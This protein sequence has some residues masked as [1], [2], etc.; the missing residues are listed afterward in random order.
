MGQFGLDDWADVAA[1]GDWPV[2]LAGNGA[3]RVVS[4]LFAYPSL[5]AVADLDPDDR[6][7]FEDI[8]TTNFEEVLR[9]LA[10]SVVVCQQ[11]GHDVAELNGRINSVRHALVAT[12]NHH[13]VA[14]DDVQG[15]P[16]LAIKGALREYEIV[17]TT[18]YDLLFYWA[19][20]FDGAGDFIDH[21][22][23]A[24]DNHFDP[25]DSPIWN[26]RTAVYWLHGGLHIH[27][28]DVDGTAKRVNNGAA[29]L[30][31]FADDG[32]LPL[33]VAEGTADQKRSAIR[34]SD[35]LTHCFETLQAEER[36]I[37]VFGQALGQ[38]DEHIVDA[39]K[40]HHA[41]RIAYGVHPTS[42]AEV[43]L[44]CASVAHR[45]QTETVAYFDST[46]HPLGS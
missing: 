18:S 6:D 40:G 37:V 14:W 32:T 34:R 26:N 19:M 46:T 22:W 9:A 2:L 39:L 11:L 30:A 10:I 13:H 21:F 38:S 12:V 3:S 25:Y 20:N 1:T 23:H 41:G 27:R 43:N 36:P 4:D 42:Q 35:Y 15:A 24:P 8:G 7:L 45:L 16:L 44:T 29:L 17:F 33:Y 5:L 31:Q 28:W